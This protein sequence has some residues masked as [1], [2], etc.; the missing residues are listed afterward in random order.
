VTGQN[1][2][3]IVVWTN[4]VVDARYTLSVPEQR[5][6]LWLAAQIEREDDALD[7]RENTIPCYR[8]YTISGHR[9]YKS[10]FNRIAKHLLGIITVEDLRK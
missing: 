3:K 4:A 8:I 6:I 7:Y 2:D 1:G 10:S 5:L 9:Y